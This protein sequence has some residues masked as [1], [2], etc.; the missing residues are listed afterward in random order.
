MPNS[1]LGDHA[2]NGLGLFIKARRKIKEDG[3]KEAQVRGGGPPRIGGSMKMKGRNRN[4]QMR[5]G[6]RRNEA[7][8]P[9]KEIV[10]A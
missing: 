9:D 4:L 8:G 3:G 7:R 6:P 5:E 10:S 2:E 1:L